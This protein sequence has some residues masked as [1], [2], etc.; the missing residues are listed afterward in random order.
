MFS[1]DR[2]NEPIDVTIDI[3]SLNGQLIKS[4][5][6]SFLPSGLNNVKIDWDIN[7]NVN[8]GIYIYKVLITSN[9][10]ESI[11]EKSEKLI[12]VR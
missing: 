2:P 6:K 9:N 5:S 11:G 12:I 1:H 4:I 10:N 8:P 3:F 7:A